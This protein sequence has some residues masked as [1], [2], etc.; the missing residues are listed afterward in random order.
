M[1]H[2]NV[3]PG[4]AQYIGYLAVYE[5]LAVFIFT[6]VTFPTG[7]YH[8]RQFRR[9]TAIKYITYYQI[10]FCLCHL[11]SS[12]MLWKKHQLF[13]RRIEFKSQTC[14]SLA[15]RLY[16]SHLAPPK[17]LL[18]SHS[19]AISHRI[20]IGTERKNTGKLPNIENIPSTY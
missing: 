3:P 11:C 12:K 4:V 16:E 18:M 14:H 1:A 9:I 13:F 10:W 8:A 19:I 7:L 5:T 15:M 20:V 2:I 17:A 6:I